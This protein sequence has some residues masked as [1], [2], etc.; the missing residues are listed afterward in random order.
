MRQRLGHD[1]NGVY[2]GKKEKNGAPPIAVAFNRRRRLQSARPP[3]LAARPPPITAR[4][5]QG[6]TRPALVAARAR[7]Q[8]P[9]RAPASSSYLLHSLVLG[10]VEGERGRTQEG[11]GKS[12]GDGWMRLQPFASPF[13]SCPGGHFGPIQKYKCCKWDQEGFIRRKGQSS[14]RTRI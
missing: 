10:F 13:S 5:P 2:Q 6:A 1:D 9:A 7:L 4:R 12:T 14:G 8:S 11:E 3:P